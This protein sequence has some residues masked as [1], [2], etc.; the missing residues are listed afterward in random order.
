[1]RYGALRSEWRACLGVARLAMDWRAQMSNNHFTW[2][3]LCMALLAPLGMIGLTGRWAYGIGMGAGVSLLALATLWWATLLFSLL[4]QNHASARLVPRMRS[5]TICVLLFIG[6]AWTLGLAAL[7][8]LAGAAPLAA[9]AGVGALFAGAAVFI[10]WPGIALAAVALMVVAMVADSKAVLAVMHA[11]AWPVAVLLALPLMLVLA[12]SGLF[13]L[14]NEAE[15]HYLRVPQLHAKKV[16][17]SFRFGAGHLL[18]RAIHKGRLDHLFMHGLGPRMRLPWLLILL[19]VI[20]F[21][22]VL[23]MWG[24]AAAEETR[25]L[26]QANLVMVSLLGLYAMPPSV[27]Q[28]LARSQAEQALLRLCGKAPAAGL[29]NAMLARAFMRQF[30][31]L[32]VASILAVLLFGWGGGVRAD[33]LLCLAPAFALPLLHACVM[34][35]DYASASSARFGAR[36][37]VGMMAML[38]ASVGWSLAALGARLLAAPS[39]AIAAALIVA[40]ALLVRARWNAMLA[41]APALPVGRLA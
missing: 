40:S 19:P 32:W 2:L 12:C 5:R 3:F 35:R 37:G 29:L 23:V 1:M 33:D 25:F 22:S 38:T 10:A 31:T 41:A 36:G 11:G 14:A 8:V 17:H 6:T 27:P 30:L 28:A 7:F 15:L 4:M 21:G 34:L 20:G 26:L 9:L 39:L 18:Q 13:R 24:G 16:D